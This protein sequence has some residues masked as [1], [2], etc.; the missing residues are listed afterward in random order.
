MGH[1]LSTLVTGCE[2]GLQ[3]SQGGIELAE[4]LS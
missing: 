2:G 3:L 1:A 4:A